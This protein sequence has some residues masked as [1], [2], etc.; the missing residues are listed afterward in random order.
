MN[1]QVLE[2][3]DSDAVR[4]QD[5]LFVIGAL[6]NSSMGRDLAWTHLCTNLNKYVDLIS[7]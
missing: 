7:R 2:F 4:S 1:L 6:A 5:A 3:A